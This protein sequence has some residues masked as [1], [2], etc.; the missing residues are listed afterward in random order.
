LVDPDLPSS[1]RVPL[2]ASGGVV[3]W[4]SDSLEV[5]G[6]GGQVF[7]MAKEG[8]HRLVAR[9]AATGGSAETWI[10]VKAL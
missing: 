9:D 4:E 2:R 3:R 10:V 1:A 5:R 7:A 8:R 6:S